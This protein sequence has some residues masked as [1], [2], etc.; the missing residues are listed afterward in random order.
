M[1]VCSLW[2]ELSFWRKLIGPWRTHRYRPECEEGYQ[3]SPFEKAPECV[4]DGFYSFNL[5]TNYIFPALRW[6]ASV[7]QSS[8]LQPVNRSWSTR[9][10]EV[11]EPSHWISRLLDLFFQCQRGATALLLRLSR[12]TL[13]GHPRSLFVRSTKRSNISIASLIS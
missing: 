8:P 6:K 7:D 5:S 13:A 10:F 3:R 4:S 1:Y 12:W 2:H 9:H 11:R